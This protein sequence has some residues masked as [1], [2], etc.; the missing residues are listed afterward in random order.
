MN[1][2]I[3]HT[4]LQKGFIATFCFLGAGQSVTR[5]YKSSEIT[6]AIDPPLEKYF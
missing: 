1:K 5:S 6:A 2:N 3:K 4:L